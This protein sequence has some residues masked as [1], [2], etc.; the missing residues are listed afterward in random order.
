M[1]ATTDHKDRKGKKAVFIV[2]DHP[3]VQEGLAAVVNQQRDLEVCG[4][5]GSARDAL[6]S[7]AAVKPDIVIVDLSLQD[8]N[9]LELI[10]DLHARDH[11]LPL[12]VL[13]MHDEALYAERVVHAGAGGYV[14]KREPMSVLLTAVRHVLNGEVYLSEQLKAKIVG[15]HVGRSQPVIHSPV[16]L[17][18]DRELE[19]FELTGQG[20][21]TREIA[22]R[23]KLSMKTVSCYR[24]S[25]KL[26]LG[27]KNG[28]ELTRQAIHW[29]EAHAG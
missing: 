20:L 8:G 10:K 11:K 13:S 1:N 14:M 26:K 29:V 22:E 17:L 19:V 12:L 28:T 27:L 5:A 3:A 15:F 21:G 18:S 16:E 25:I 24:Q 4:A 9:G 23:L 6:E 7:I 2:D